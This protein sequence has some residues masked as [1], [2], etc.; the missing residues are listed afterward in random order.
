MK[1][2]LP[3]KLSSKFKTWKTFENESGNQKFI[4]RIER[5]QF[6]GGRSS[7]CF[8]FLENAQAKRAHVNGFLE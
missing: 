6:P 8:H 5:R 7:G 3:G 2:K 1:W 4:E